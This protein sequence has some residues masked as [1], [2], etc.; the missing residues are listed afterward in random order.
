MC[1]WWLFALSLLSAALLWA[2]WGISLA[3]HAHAKPFTTLGLTVRRF[4]LV[5]GSAVLAALGVALLRERRRPRVGASVV[6]AGIV[7]PRNPVR[8]S[9]A[10]GAGSNKI[11]HA[12]RPG[13]AWLLFVVPLLFLALLWA[14]LG[15]SDATSTD[16]KPFTALAI[17]HGSNGTDDPDTRIVIANREGHR[18]EYDLEIRSGDHMT[19][20]WEGIVVEDGSDWRAEL[21]GEQIGTE[22][23]SIVTLFLRGSSQPYRSLRTRV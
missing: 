13:A 11:V 20:R 17:E 10:G 22:G 6:A 12:P 5:L 18:A 14:A 15:I 4:V 19:T 9:A 8:G 21:P 3:A 1:A 16:P 7:Q 23:E 2:A